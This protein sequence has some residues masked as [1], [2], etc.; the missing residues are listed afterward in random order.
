MLPVWY[1]MLFV[2]F[3]NQFDSVF[4][5]PFQRGWCCKPPNPP[6]II[7]EPITVFHGWPHQQGSLTPGN[8]PSYSFDR[9]SCVSDISFPN[10]KIF[11]FL[12]PERHPALRWISSPQNGS[13]YRSFLL[14]PRG[15]F[16]PFLWYNP[17][18]C[19]HADSVSW[20]YRSFIYLLPPDIVARS[21]VGYVW[22]CC[23]VTVRSIR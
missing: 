1:Q 11:F 7:L 13:V 19:A 4:P 9:P 2:L 18:M 12:L 20:W 6:P 10:A 23:R 14:M 17:W 22:P 5:N 15:A 21:E 3:A 16:Q 8:W